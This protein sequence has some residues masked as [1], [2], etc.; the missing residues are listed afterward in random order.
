MYGVAKSYPEGSPEYN[1]AF[2]TAQRLYPNDADAATNAAAVWLAQGKTAEAKAAL[3]QVEQTA[4]VCNALGIVYA[5]E[6]DYARA[7]ELF[8]KAAAQG[9]TEAK[10]NL[11]AMQK[12]VKEFNENNY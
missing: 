3:Q 12:Y 8:G 11:E 6:K 1:E 7:E 9:C 2:L 10:A 5:R 4:G